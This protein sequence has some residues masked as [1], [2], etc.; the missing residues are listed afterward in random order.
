M[1]NALVAEMAVNAVWKAFSTTKVRDALIVMDDV[2]RI[3][4]A[5]C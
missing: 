2:E 5:L 1:F 4:L 3:L